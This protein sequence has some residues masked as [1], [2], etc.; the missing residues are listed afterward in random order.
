MSFFVDGLHSELSSVIS[1]VLLAI[2]ACTLN[3][4]NLIEAKNDA[5]TELFSQIMAH[6]DATITIITNEELKDS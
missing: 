4:Y 1:L 5:V 3:I 2:G 6:K